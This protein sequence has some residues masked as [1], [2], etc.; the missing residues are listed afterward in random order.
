MGATDLLNPPEPG[1]D[2]VG[3]DR[4]V[5]VCSWPTCASEAPRTA[6]VDTSAR[7][8]ISARG[9]L[10]GP[11]RVA[12]RVLPPEPARRAEQRGQRASERARQR[13]GDDRHEHAGRD[14]HGDRAEPDE[15]RSPAWPAPRPAA[16]TPARSAPGA[17]DHARRRSDCRLRP[18]CARR[19][20][21]PA[22]FARRA[23]RERSPTARSPRRRPR[24]RRPTVRA[25]N[26][27]GADGQRDAERLEQRLEA[28]RGHDAEPETDQ[29][30]D[31]SQSARPRRAPTGTT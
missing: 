26:T 29:R 4:A 16:T 22:G 19:A 6:I 9:G 20:R 28:D 25:S 11:A 12:H 8:I 18:R 13:P 24:S 17:G 31:Q 1:D 7:P 3:A 2:V 5:D 14:E 15:P 10:C 21:P 27:S 30:R 23:A